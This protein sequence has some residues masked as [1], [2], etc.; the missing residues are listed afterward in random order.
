MAIKLNTLNT[1]HFSNRGMRFEDDINTSNEYYYA[2]D[3]A[4]IH[5][6]PTPITIS[7]VDYPSRD[8]AK[9]TEA[10]YKNKSTT[11]YNGIYKGFY[12]DFEAKESKNKTTFPK[13]NIKKHQ[14]DHLIKVHKHG[15]IGFVLIKF[16]QL[17][18][19]YLVLVNHFLLCYNMD[20]RKTS[21]DIEL[22]RKYGFKVTEK[23]MPRVDY[24]NVVDKIINDG[25]LNVE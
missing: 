20:N 18:E 24:I 3:I 17:N 5:K 22:I 4:I 6:K 12:I 1:K 25:Y 13:N 8:K 23:Y 7:K 9:I 19:I 11:D 15:G 14:I 16:S 2:N 21:I 10:Y